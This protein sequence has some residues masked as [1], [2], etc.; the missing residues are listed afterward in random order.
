MLAAR[1]QENLVYSHQAAGAAKPLNQG[2]RQFP[3][4]TPGNK[5]PK[6]PLK[7]PLKDENGNG[8]FAAGK[9]GFK[10]AR[11]NNI[12]NATMMT[13]KGGLGGGNAFVTPLATR[14][15]APLGMKTTNAK[16][17]AFQTPAP[18]KQ[19]GLGDKKQK[20]VS[21][22]KAKPRVSHA[23]MT[24]LDIPGD[25][26]T[27]E[28]RDIEYMPPKPKGRNIILPEIGEILTACRATRYSGR[29]STPGL[30]DSER[31]QSDV[32]CSKQTR[33][34]WSQHP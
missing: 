18:I 5:A 20:S 10:S 30:F 16:M 27:V 19:D 4:K 14:T 9:D 22:R 26:E 28:E 12:E 8:G 29:P 13:K 6:T 15:R 23:E 1:D 2:T 21:A 34:G 33:V 32:R 3:P 24:K 7:L 11:S 31:L 25:H 17:K